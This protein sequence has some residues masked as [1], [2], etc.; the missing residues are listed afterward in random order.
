MKT[1]EKEQPFQEL[2]Q[3][4]LSEL[5]AQ[6]LAGQGAPNGQPAGPAAAQ[7]KPAHGKPVLDVSWVRNDYATLEDAARILG[8][9]EWAWELWIQKGAL[10]GIVSDAGVGKTRLVVEW[11]AR[12][13]LASPMPDGS[14]N[15]F[16]AKTRTLWL[17]Y[18]RNWKGVIRSARQFGLPEKAIIL[19]SRK[20]KP[21]WLPDFDSAD[22][23]E[24]LREFIVQHAPG[25]VVIDS[26]TY[27]S[28]Y[29]TGKPNEAKIAYDPIMDL[30]MEFNTAGI[31]ITHTNARGEILNRRPLERVRTKIDITRPDPSQPTRLRIEVTKSDDKLP[32]PIGAEFTDTA[33]TYDQNAPSTPL[34]PAT[35]KPSRGRP[36][37]TSPGMAEFLLKYLESGPAALRQIIQ[38]AQDTGLLKAPTAA[39]PKPSATALYDAKEW[40]ERMHPDKSVDEFLVR[41]QSGKDLKHWQLID[42]ATS[43]ASANQGQP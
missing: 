16:P 41:V 9:L 25:F 39:N 23:I 2:V 22:T 5:I 26:T 6:N 3:D 43:N 34:S 30:L 15:P 27:A 35:G 33:I 37:T 31:A 40:I 36:A 42:K 17:M 28:A 10:A 14:P 19:P 4:V 29:N 38:T 18:D 20:E 32:P 13:W 24:V 11:C 21:L 8:N 7:G 1:E 12:L